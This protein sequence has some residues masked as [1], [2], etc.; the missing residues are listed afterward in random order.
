LQVA[1]TYT[2][3]EVGTEEPTKSEK[4]TQCVAEVTCS[5]TQTS[6]LKTTETSTQAGLVTSEASTQIDRVTS[7]ASTHIE[8][9]ISEAATQTD[10]R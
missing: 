10:S 1:V 5:G 7:E 4:S 9:V 3:K 8:R 6:F 2:E